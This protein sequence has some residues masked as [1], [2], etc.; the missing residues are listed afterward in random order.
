MIGGTDITIPTAA[1]LSAIDLAIRL[2][3]MRWPNAVFEDAI[4]GSVFNRYA[5]LA[6]RFVR[7]LFVYRD[8]VAR[9]QWEELGADP[10]NVN[11]MVHLLVSPST[12]TVVVDNLDDAMI[13]ETVAA[14]ESALR[15]DILT[16]TAE[17]RVAA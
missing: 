7:E 10:S 13:R 16:L 1:G 8:E 12:L 4:N 17:L 15:M 3:R 5:D 11:T 9:Q 2:L 6:F 14:I